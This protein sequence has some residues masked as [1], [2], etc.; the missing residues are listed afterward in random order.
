MDVR[1]WFDHPTPRPRV[2]TAWTSRAL[3]RPHGRDD[4]RSE[5]RLVWLGRPP[6]FEF[7]TRCAKLYIPG[8]QHEIALS[9]PS[10]GAGWVNDVLQASAV[11]KDRD[12]SYPS[13]RD[14]TRAFPGTAAD[15]S[16]F[17]QHPSWKRIR[18]AGLLLV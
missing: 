11:T 7:R 3:E 9:V 10:E 15:L 4:V 1:Q 12:G 14:V 2:S 18:S 8:G 17:M 16:R 6:V 13:W 5:R